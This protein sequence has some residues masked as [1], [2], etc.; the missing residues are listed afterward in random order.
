[1]KRFSFF[2]ILIV[3]MAIPNFCCG[4]D[5]KDKQSIAAAR[6]QFKQ[7]IVQFKDHQNKEFEQFKQQVREIYGGRQSQSSYQRSNNAYRESQ[8]HI[9]LIWTYP[10]LPYMI[11][12]G[13]SFLSSSEFVNVFF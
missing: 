13:Y 3:A 1:M 8:E 7:S 9:G 2:V 5:A 6:Q 10:T 4:A 11:K 12:I